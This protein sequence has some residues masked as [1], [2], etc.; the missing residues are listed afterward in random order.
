MAQSYSAVLCLHVA[1]LLT[2]LCCPHSTWTM[3]LE[4]FGHTLHTKLTEP[5]LS[6]G[7][8]LSFHFAGLLVAVVV[9]HRF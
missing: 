5:I 7:G 8:R 6:A 9:E 1:Y 3:L 4:A 2:T